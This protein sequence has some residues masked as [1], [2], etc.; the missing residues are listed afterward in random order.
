[1]KW[2]VNE[3]GLITPDDMEQKGVK[4]EQQIC[5]NKIE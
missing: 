3:K 4:L 2:S 5:L 1:M